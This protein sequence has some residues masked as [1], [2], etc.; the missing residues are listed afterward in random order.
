[1]FYL[2]V[3][4]NLTTLN[5]A[6][7]VIASPFYPRG[8]PNYQA[9][10]WQITASKGS[11]VVMAIEDMSIQNC[12]QTCAC[13]YLKVQGGFYSDGYIGERRCGSYSARYYSMSE[14]L[15]VL[16]VSDGS[17]RKRYRGFKA[18][19]LQ[20]NHS[21]LI[22]G[23]KRKNVILMTM[24]ICKALKRNNICCCKMLSKRAT[25][26]YCIVVVKY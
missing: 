1:M 26:E 11:H 25:R 23:K 19:Y 3:C 9:C 6:S 18:T 12:G 17:Y 24:T 8:Y 2:T 7:G 5:D 14:N 15:T 22:P 4:S 10:H 16:F 13:D 21:S 20:L